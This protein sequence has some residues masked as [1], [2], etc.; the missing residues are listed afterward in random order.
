MVQRGEPS[1]PPRDSGAVRTR[2]AVV[3]LAGILGWSY[4]KVQVR[5][6]MPSFSAKTTLQIHSGPGEAG[7]LLSNEPNGGQSQAS[8]EL[9]T[10][11]Y[12]LVNTELMRQVI[13]DH[14]LLNNSAFTG[15]Y[16]TPVSLD[17]LARRLLVMVQA[18]LRPGTS[19]IDVTVAGRDGSL[20]QDLADWITD[21]AIKQAVNRRLSANEVAKSIL[22]A[23]TERLKLKL[24]RAEEA[25]LEYR[26]SSELV[27]PIDQRIALLERTLADIN[28]ELT[29]LTLAI[30]QIGND[31]ALLEEL[32]DEPSLEQLRAV[33]SVY[34]SEG[35]VRV[36]ELMT[37]HDQALEFIVDDQ[38]GAM[39]DHENVAGTLR[40]RYEQALLAAPKLLDAEF[41]RLKNQEQTLQKALRQTEME[42]L[43]V[44]DKRIEYAVLK[45]EVDATQALYDAVMQRVKE[46]DLTAGMQDQ[47]MSVVERAHRAVDTTPDPM[48]TLIGTTLL[49][50]VLGGFGVYLC[51]RLRLAGRRG[52]TESRA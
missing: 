42:V 18:R 32:G 23:E 13:I 26:R 33:P 24:Q 20:V 48:P 29:P 39:A 15:G 52:E 7:R 51:D 12:T 16:A 21:G 11:S 34:N 40:K 4:A 46:V 5:K 31:L 8:S 47:V 37:R 22:T 41:E 30:S 38:P 2:I 17:R 3:V 19:L 6:I 27:I 9:N 36:R 1:Q 49:G 25:I 44:S 43:D 14:D 10:L 28:S 45:R 35:V 50:L